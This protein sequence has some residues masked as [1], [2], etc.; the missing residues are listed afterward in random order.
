MTNSELRSILFSRRYLRDD[1][2]GDDWINEYFRL[3]VDE[4]K[5]T[6]IEI[7]V[8]NSLQRKCSC[9]TMRD[10]KIIILD[11]YLSELFIIFNQ[12]LINEEDT[13][14]LE[15]LFYKITYESYYVKGDRINAAKY[16]WITLKKNDEVGDM[17]ILQVTRSS[18]PQYLYTQQTFLVMHEVM[19]SFF[20]DF[21]EIYR[22]KK[23]NITTVL[24]TI[25]DNTEFCLSEMVSD[26]YLEELC[27][28]YLAAITSI[29]M[30][31]ENEHCSE[32]D[33]ACAIIMALQY[34]YML[35]CIDQ[36]VDVDF[37]SNN[38][39]DQVKEFAVRVMIV[40]LF[41]SNYFEIYNPDME[42]EINKCML[43]KISIWENRFLK[44]LTDFLCIQKIQNMNE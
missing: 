5:L 18:K 3:T 20:K 22:E 25:F 39:T 35:F 29:S 37:L 17:T 8:C 30:S 2:V 6:D 31:V 27:C 11:N 38:F 36:M 23:Q 41:V 14:Y 21:P 28:D 24:E 1:P 15:T 32:E 9:A 12:M 42:S 34:Q 10:K 7:F 33:A 44:P 43:E 19:H 40:R 13:K 16:R 4:L 26:R